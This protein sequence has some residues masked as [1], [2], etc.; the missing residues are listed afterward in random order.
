[1]LTEIFESILEVNGYTTVT[2]GN[3]IKVIPDNTAASKNLETI[4]GES[5]MTGGRQQRH[6]G[7][8]DHSP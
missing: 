5:P 2:S 8:S 4:S 1:M 6:Y 7:H 3:V